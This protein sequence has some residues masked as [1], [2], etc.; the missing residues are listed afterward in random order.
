MFPNRKPSTQGGRGES[1]TVA[2]LEV[3]LNKLE[4]VV[5]RDTCT[6]E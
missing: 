1:G 6:I 2:L 3:V 4:C 5:Q